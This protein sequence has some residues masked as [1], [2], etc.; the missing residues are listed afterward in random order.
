M[1]FDSV[2]EMNEYY[3]NGVPSNVLAIVRTS[4]DKSVLFA[5]SN[6]K[7]VSGE[8]Q[9]GYNTSP[10]DLA[11]I[12]YLEENK[13][14]KSELEGLASQE[15]VSERI[16]EVNSGVEV[17]LDNYVTKS[18]LSACGYLT[19]HQDLSDYALKNEI[20]SLNGYATEAWVGNQ[21]FLTQHQNLSDYLTK[22][23]IASAGYLTSH[24][25][26]SGYATE[27]YVDSKI[28]DVVGAAP[29]ALDTLKEIGDA[30]NNDADFAGTMTSALAGKA[31][32]SDVYTK[33]QI[34][35]AGYLTSH[36]SLSGYATEAWVGNQGFLT[37][38]QSLVD[39]PT[40]AEI[41][42]AGYITAHQDLSNY[43]LKS[44]LPVVPSLEGYATEAY[45]MSQGF[46]TEHQDLSDYA[47]KSELPEVPSLE[48]YATE[49]YV[50]SQGFL[51]EHQSLSDYATKA[52]VSAA[53]YLTSHQ[54]LE[55]YA[56]E[57]YVMG[58]GFLTEH[59]D[60]TN[61]ALKSEIPSEVS[62]DGYATQEW[63]SNAGYLTSHQ[64]LSDYATK[65][66]IEA[67][68]YL[69][70]HQSLEGY[71]TE[72][73]VMGKGFLT[74]H[75]DLTDYALKSELP[76]VPSL[77]GY[78][79][80]AY[81]MSKG[82]LTEHQS[83]SDY[84]TKDALSNAGYITS[85]QSLSGYATEAYV[86]S[87]IEDVVGAAPAALDTLKEI[88]DS[89]NN[90]SDFAGTMTTALSGK[91]NASDV[92]TKQE[93][94]A[95]GYLTS[96]QSLTDYVT[97]S[98]LSECGYLTSHQSLSDYA[99]KSELPV[100]P[101]LEGYATEAYV[102]GKGF[103]T[104]HQSLSDYV[105][106]SELSECGYLTSH[107]SLTDYV[108]KTDLE[109]AS[110]LTAVPAGYATE[111]YVMSK[112]FLTEHQSL[113]DYATK[114]EISAAGYLTSHQSL[115]DYVT[116][117]DLTNAAYLTSHQSLA[118]YATEA[119]V[120]NA[121]N[122]VD[123]A[124]TIGIWVDNGST[125]VVEN[126]SIENILV[127]ARLLQQES[128]SE[129]VY[130]YVINNGFL[131]WDDLEQGFYGLDGL[132]NEDNPYDVEDPSTELNDSIFD[133]LEQSN[134]VEIVDFEDEENEGEGA[135]TYVW[136]NKLATKNYVDSNISY[137]TALVG[138]ANT[139][140]EY[141]INGGEPTT[142]DEPSEEDAWYWNEEEGTVLDTDTVSE[143]TLNIDHNALSEYD[144][145][146]AEALYLGSLIDGD[147]NLHFYGNTWTD[148]EDESI[149]AVVNIIIAD[150]DTDCIDGSPWV[151][152]F[153]PDNE[154]VIS[155]SPLS[156]CFGEDSSI[157]SGYDYI[158][159]LSAEPNDGD[160]LAY[161]TIT[162]YKGQTTPALELVNDN[163]E[164]PFFLPEEE[165]EENISE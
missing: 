111:A 72:A 67:A 113:S 134:I 129:N 87:K 21:G 89:L 32:A 109:N 132:Y 82:F 98:A 104:E 29:A 26:L 25:S 116:K 153:E 80:E 62:L 162:K 142:P 140:A 119:Y 100:V 45:V 110:Y 17:S 4:E 65:A 66:E 93:I 56:T 123:T 16:I 105:S 128:Y 154:S 160:N 23:E 70:A 143:L 133:I 68:G 52:E 149:P 59:Q 137:L 126:K 2:E 122:G 102:M 91:A 54:S 24:Q 107:Q 136:V 8:V 22:A 125:M 77:D 37:Q 159:N 11:R 101:S 139:I 50:M 9:G 42:A 60:L 35:A 18:G 28:E 151:I 147:Y 5:T 138:N 20:P 55:G 48:G 10:E 115:T 161:I 1:Y 46:I 165:E 34:D 53:G 3:E 33:A 74:E 141:I 64:D 49:S 7:N 51:T 78:A 164:L 86:M 121:I 94:D 148:K 99:L 73:Y 27:N 90:D 85:H 57:A 79:T 83:L 117:T 103:L 44:E 69:T 47:L 39:Y 95:A 157:S 144:S 127:E 155:E 43:A 75:Q 92:Y 76:V 58:K 63:V 114:A 96:H 6:N 145:D 130:A 112:G 156:I 88:G 14:D 81:V 61:Y 36:Q 40:K 19:S 124:D 38:H 31:N 135:Y 97:K 71:A 108:T 15:Y 41:S 152:Q 150:K 118:G 146:N 13:A 120:T 106:K 163:P 158:L 30:L 84:V 131:T 12:S